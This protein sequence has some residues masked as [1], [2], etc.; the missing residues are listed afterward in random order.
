MTI[1]QYLLSILV[2]SSSETT[3][4]ERC[5]ELGMTPLESQISLNTLWSMGLVWHTRDGWRLTASGVAHV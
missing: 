4:M 2:S 1:L 3:F 5:G